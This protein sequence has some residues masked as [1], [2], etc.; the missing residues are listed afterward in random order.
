MSGTPVVAACLSYQAPN[1][2]TMLTSDG[3]IWQENP[4]TDE[5]HWLDANRINT[6]WNFVETSVTTAWVKTSLQGMLRLRQVQ[7]F[8]QVDMTVTGSSPPVYTNLCGLEINLAVNYN[9]TIVQTDSWNYNQL[10][11]LNINGQVQMS[12][13]AMWNQAMAYQITVNDTD[14]GQVGNTG[15][16]AIFIGI[17][18]ETDI[19]GPR[20]NLLPARAKH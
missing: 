7:L 4:P 11:K 10:Y 12:C 9:S 15:V 1:L 16:G 20:Y 3:T 6:N 5:T 18:L 2:F 14:G 13:G 19:L 8:T 17:A